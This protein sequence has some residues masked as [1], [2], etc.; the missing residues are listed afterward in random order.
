MTVIRFLYG[1]VA[2]AWW[3]YGRAVGAAGC[4]GGWGVEGWVEAWMGGGAGGLRVEGRGGWGSGC[5]GR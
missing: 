5:A 3:A 1:H 2:G 4:V